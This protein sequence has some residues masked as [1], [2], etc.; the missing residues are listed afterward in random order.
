VSAGTFDDRRAWRT[1][2][3]ATSVPAITVAL[4]TLEPDAG[5]TLEPNA[6]GER[7]R[8]PAVC[9]SRG[10]RFWF[11]IDDYKRRITVHGTYGTMPDGRVWIPRDHVRDAVDP[12]PTISADKLPEQIAKDV[13][14]RFLPD[15]RKHLDAYRTALTDAT[16]FRNKTATLLEEIVAL[17]NGWITADTRNDARSAER[18]ASLYNAPG[19]SYGSL[20]VS[21]EHVRIEVSVTPEFA[22]RFAA[23]FATGASTDDVTPSKTRS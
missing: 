20:R 21:G 4:A 5:W 15:Y 9:N 10:E 8:N 7:Y 23:L 19:I 16:A 18:T 1:T 2:F 3:Y 12:S 11:G 13:V 14:R 6:D 17:G 22:K